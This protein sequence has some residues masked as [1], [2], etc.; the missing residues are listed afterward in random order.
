[1]IKKYEYQYIKK[2]NRSEHILSMIRI[3]IQI[4]KNSFKIN[5]S[6]QILQLIIHNHII[7]NQQI[8][9]NNKVHSSQI[10]DNNGKIFLNI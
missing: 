8:F 1:M 7:F 5:K 9:L 2:W 10:K 6:S 3:M 4:I